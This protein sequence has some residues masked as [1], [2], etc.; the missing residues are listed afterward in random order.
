MECSL[1]KRQQMGE[2]RADGNF[3][4]VLFSLLL[5]VFTPRG[6]QQEIGAKNG[7]GKQKA[8]TFGRKSHT[9]QR[10]WPRSRNIITTKQE[11][12]HPLMNL[13]AN[14]CTKAYALYVHTWDVCIWRRPH[15]LN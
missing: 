5:R 1:M 6:S 3:K 10:A 2:T 4:S 15:P 13:R 14:S 7:K 9:L 12:A 11:Q 8:R